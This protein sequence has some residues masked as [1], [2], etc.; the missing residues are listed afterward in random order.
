MDNHVIPT[1]TIGRTPIEVT[2][3]GFGGGALGGM[4]TEVDAGAA[5]ESVRV[6]YAAGIRYFDTA[7]LYG[8][9]LSEHRIGEALE[10]VD[11][12]SYVLGTKVGIDI[13]PAPTG[14]DLSTYADPFY[15]DG[16]YDFSAAACEQSIERS[17]KRL[18]TD[19][20][21]IVYIHDPDEGDSAVPESRRRGVSHAAQVLDETFPFLAGLKAQGAIG[22]VGVGLNGTGMLH[23]FARH[24][25]FDCFL[26]AGR[27]TLLEQH[28][29][30]DLFPTC[31]DKGV[32]INIG[33]VFNSGILATGSSVRHAKYNYEDAD[34]YVLSTVRRIE[35]IGQRYGVALPAAALRFPLLNP[36][37]S[38][39]IPGMRTASEVKQNIDA[40][41]ER[42]PDGYWN[43]LRSAELI[44]AGALA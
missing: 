21:D 29:L 19:H 6:A 32:T 28:G 22:A 26:L 42:I 33:G 38:S 14:G 9:G 1:R 12:S 36:V 7:P 44:A 10:G 15:I 31:A 24:A 35:D 13:N 25:E 23:T 3:I 39:V 17:M 27:Y 16:G 40:Y 37:V 5:I 41:R 8:H 43:E 18:R 4:F 11:R 34:P 20:I 30:D 2:E